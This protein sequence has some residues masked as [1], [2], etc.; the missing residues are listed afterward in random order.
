MD[1]LA[2]PEYAMHEAARLGRQR[3]MLGV[4]LL[5]NG[6]PIGVI[7]LLRTVVK[8]FTEKQIELVTAFADQA[9]IAIENARLLKRAARVPSGA[10]GYVGGASGHQQLSGRSCSRCLRPCWRMPCA[11]AT[12]SS[13]ISFAGMATPCT[14]LRR[15]IH[16]LL[17][18]SSA[19]AHRFVPVQKIL[20]VAWWRRK[21][22][23]T[24]PTCCRDAAYIDRRDP[25][26]VAAVELGGIRTFLAVPMLKENELI[27]AFIVYRQEVRPFTDKQIALVTNFA[28][29]AVIAIENARLLNELRQRTDLILRLRIAGAADRDLGGAPG[30]QPINLRSA[31]RA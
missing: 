14:S 11:S 19:G 25:A 31:D 5:H 30:H 1:C 18:P 24:S 15:I 28:A 22:L 20:S 29:Q 4:P 26:V 6:I 8:P 17:S 16:R 9:V 7:G 3:S 23:F 10:N 13:E 21:R 12:L 2:D 27:G